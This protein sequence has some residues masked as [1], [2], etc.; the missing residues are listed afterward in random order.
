MLGVPAQLPWTFLPLLLPRSFSIRQ[1][2]IPL[3]GAG[4][5]IALTMPGLWHR[6]PF[7]GG[8]LR[9]PGS[10]SALLLRFQNRT[11]ACARLRPARRNRYLCFLVFLPAHPLLLRAVR[12]VSCKSD[13]KSKRSR[14][15]IGNTRW[16]EKEFGV[17]EGRKKND[18]NAAD[19]PSLPAL[20]GSCCRSDSIGS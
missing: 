17:N 20:W 13:K 8:W 11:R 5:V 15:H 7:D 12:S 1:F 3:P 10:A 6:A 9:Q 14:S 18:P 19:L 16:S 4:T 2:L